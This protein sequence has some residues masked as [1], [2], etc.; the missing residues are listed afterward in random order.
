MEEIA[1][2][3]RKTTELL[4]IQRRSIFGGTDKRSTSTMRNGTKN[5]DDMTGSS[6][7]TKPTESADG[8]GGDSDVQT[9]QEL[10]PA[11]IDQTTPSTVVASST[12]AAE[13]TIQADE[14]P[15]TRSE[16]LG[17]LEI[18]LANKEPYMHTTKSIGTQTND[19]AE[20][21]PDANAI[22]LGPEDKDS[23][24]ENFIENWNMQ[25]H[26]C[27][28]CNK[29]FV[30]AERL[31]EHTKTSHST[32]TFQP[33]PY[34]IP[35][36]PTLTSVLKMEEIEPSGDLYIEA[37]IPGGS[38][39]SHPKTES[40]RYRVAS[41]VLWSASPV[42]RKMFGPQSP[43]REAIDLRRGSMLGFIPVLEL[44][45]NYAALRII[46]QLLHHQPK[47]FKIG[48]GIVSEMETFAIVCDK[49]ELRDALRPAAEILFKPFISKAGDPG[50]EP[51]LMVAY[52][53][54]FEDIFTQVS[55]KVIIQ[56]SCSGTD[57]VNH[58][59]GFNSRAL[60][61]LLHGMESTSTSLNLN[62][63]NCSR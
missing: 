26:Q 51:S 16:S 3:G 17:A 29:P 46:F 40:V 59:A 36:K 15:S 6:A 39:F 12:T 10:S 37:R 57:L 62:N 21:I 23:Y 19:P 13:E 14:E 18:L 58:A 24:V 30:K 8:N 1:L 34:Q 45:D 2:I 25:L 22:D 11:D 44:E 48:F 54:G 31:Q 38:L 52:I 20:F 53:F 50:Q 56:S 4:E 5:Q 32:S 28:V 42:F 27:P 35:G 55:K 47:I 9:Q 49:Y 61:Q 63:S 7:P 33:V 41:Q 60:P 43:F